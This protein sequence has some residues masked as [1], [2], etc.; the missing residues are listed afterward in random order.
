MTKEE[1]EQKFGRLIRPTDAAE[2]YDCTPGRI[3]Q[4]QK[5]GKLKKIE[6]D[7]PPKRRRKKSTQ[8]LCIESEIKL[9]RQ[10]KEEKEAQKKKEPNNPEEFKEMA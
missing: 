6:V 1:A 7:I 5:E 3:S 4:M 8:T 10:E 9:L 2:I